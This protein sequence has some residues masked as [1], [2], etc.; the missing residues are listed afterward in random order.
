VAYP[1]LDPNPVGTA[2]AN[3][4]KSQRPA[5]G[6]PITDA[7]L[8]ALWQGIVNILYTDLKAN[9]GINPGTFVVAG[10]QAG[11]STLPVTGIGG[12]AE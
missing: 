10:V 11:G 9:M 1:N 12:P 7:E 6:S 3:F 2:I 8:I 4:V 5:P